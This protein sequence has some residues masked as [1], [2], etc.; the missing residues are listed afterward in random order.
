[1]GR[2]LLVVINCCSVQ[3]FPKNGLVQTYVLLTCSY[4]FAII[5]II[6]IKL[7]RHNVISMMWYHHP[8][9]RQAYNSC[10]NCALNKVSVCFNCVRNDPN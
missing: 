2:D 4:V 10:Y 1:M 7:W 5:I 8:S 9:F 3:A 6:I